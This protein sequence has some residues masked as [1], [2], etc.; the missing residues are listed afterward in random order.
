MFS[1]LPARASS[2]MHEFF[3]TTVHHLVST[4]TTF[5][6]S[7]RAGGNG[8]TPCAPPSVSLFIS[9]SSSRLTHT[10][11]QPE[12]HLLQHHNFPPL[13]L[14]AQVC[15]HTLLFKCNFISNETGVERF[16]PNHRLTDPYIHGNEKEDV[17]KRTAQ[18]GDEGREKC[19]EGGKGGRAGG[20]FVKCSLVGECFKCVWIL[21]TRRHSYI[22]QV[23]CL[24]KVSS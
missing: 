9:P 10:H 3:H 6:Q 17:R 22:H 2:F 18:E 21:P 7:W 5:Y 23:L 13:P 16:V 14:F 15:T 8:R 4:H 19:R 11:L 24:L 12:V 20:L 1:V